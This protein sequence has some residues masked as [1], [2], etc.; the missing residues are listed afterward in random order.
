MLLKPEAFAR[1]WGADALV[2]LPTA[3]VTAP[4]PRNARDFTG[5][6]GLPALIRYFG[7]PTDGLITF[8]RLASGLSPV[9]GEQIVG[10]PLPPEWSVY[11]IMGDEFF[12]NGATWWCIHE[13]TGQ[14]D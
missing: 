8:C 7:G 10:P 9:L 3:S 11:W 1:A 12:C 14:V 5:R 4:I 6:A 2:Q 13:R